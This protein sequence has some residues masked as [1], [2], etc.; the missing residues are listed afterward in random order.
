VLADHPAFDP[1]S[2]GGFVTAVEHVGIEVDL[3]GPF[4]GLGLRVHADL[5][6]DGRDCR[7][8]ERTLPAAVARVDVG[9]P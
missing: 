7:G 3:A 2:G 9:G 8:S 6:E 1:D 4:G 5:L